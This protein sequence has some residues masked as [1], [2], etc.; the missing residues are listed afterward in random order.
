MVYQN[1]LP[2]VAVVSQGRF[3]CTLFLLAGYYTSVQRELYDALLEVQKD[4]INLCQPET[5]TIEVIFLEMLRRLGKQLQR[6]GIL[7]ANLNSLQLQKVSL[8]I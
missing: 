7:P 2:L 5:S 1:R 4:C 6:L 8:H 3:H